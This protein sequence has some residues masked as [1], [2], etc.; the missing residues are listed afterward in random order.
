[1]KLSQL[2]RFMSIALLALS[3]AACGGDDDGGTDTTTTSEGD[4]DGDQEPATGTQTQYV[5]NTV[6]LPDNSGSDF[7]LDLDGDPEGVTDNSLGT[8]LAALSA[9]GDLGLQESVTAS[10]NNGSILLLL[11]LTTEDFTSHPNAGLKFFLG[12]TGNIT[13]APCTDETDDVCGNHLDG[14][15]QFSVASD[16]PDDAELLGPI[17]GGL[18]SGGPGTVTIQLDLSDAPGTEPITVELIGARVEVE[19]MENGLM[20]GIIGGGIPEDQLTTQVIPGIADVVVAT[21]NDSCALEGEECVCD[22]T[23]DTLAGLFDEDMNCEVTREEV[24]MNRIVSSL[25]T[26]DI[27]LLDADGNFNP[28][29]DGESDSLSVGLGFTAAAGT[30]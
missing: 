2:V 14:S 19:T 30:F 27:D 15:G 12:D 1:M 8:I 5:V 16:S 25:L 23:G 29:S 18:L 13:P 24:T 22:S 20:S 4:G 17:A 11:E 7:A 6:S 21:F 10:V 3:I 26:P 28:R 9:G